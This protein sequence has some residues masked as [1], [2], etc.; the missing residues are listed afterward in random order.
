MA[1]PAT[2]SQFFAMVAGPLAAPGPVWPPW[3]D[4][5]FGSGVQWPRA[6]TH[7]NRG[8]PGPPGPA[9]CRCPA[10]ADPGPPLPCPGVPVVIAG[11]QALGHPAAPG[12]WQCPALPL[13]T[14]AAALA[15]PDPPWG[16]VT[17]ASALCVS[18]SDFPN[19]KRVG[20]G[21]PSH[22][23]NKKEAHPR[24]LEGCLSGPGYPLGPLWVKVAGRPPAW[25][26]AK[27]GPRVGRQ[28]NRGPRTW[29]GRDCWPSAD[30]RPGDALFYLCTP[31][32]PFNGS[33]SCSPD[34]RSR[35][36]PD[37]LVRIGSPAT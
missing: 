24:W 32:N 3:A 34:K 19:K 4:P 11:T 9:T 13:D 27:P 29:I 28:A 2:L 1:A 22:F 14:R 37:W 30:R 35:D 33:S 5:R 7:L 6:G 17:T 23:P 25:G 16:G 18:P 36:D 21:S 31:G 12:V 26:T 10:P 20:R 8:D 15:R